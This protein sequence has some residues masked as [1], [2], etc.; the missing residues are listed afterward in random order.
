[1]SSNILVVPYDPK[2]VL[3]FQQ[4]S[5][6][7]QLALGDNCVKIHHVGSTAIS[8]LWAKPIIDMIPVV[9]DI[10]AVEQS[11]QAMA[12]LGFVAKGEYG[13]LFRRYFQRKA[14]LPACNVHV[15][16]EGSGEIE[17]LLLFKDFLNQHPDYKER[18]A[19]LKC[20]LSSQVNDITEYTLA[21]DALIKEID[22]LTGYKGYRI[23]HALTPREWDTYHRLLQT[24]SKQFTPALQHIVLYNGTEV[25]GAAQ[26]VTDSKLITSIHKFSIDSAEQPQTRAFFERNLTRWINKLGNHSS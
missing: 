21:K 4:E 5:Q 25:V 14:P 12:Q 17:R 1:M 22:D 15:Y 10:Y 11:N 3:Q 9:K 24:D 23:V 18:Y 2:W 8:G 19:D 13:M 16:E 6:K 7:I 26:L 20:K